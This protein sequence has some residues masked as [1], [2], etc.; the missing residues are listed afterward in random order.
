MFSQ[1]IAD[2]LG[3]QILSNRNKLASF[4]LDTLVLPESRLSSTVDHNCA[5]SLLLICTVAIFFV[6]TLCQ[7]YIHLIHAV[8]HRLHRWWSM[9]ADGASAICPRF[10][11]NF[12]VKLLFVLLDLW[13]LLLLVKIITNLKSNPVSESLVVNQNLILDAWEFL[14]DWNEISTLQL[15]WIVHLHDIIKLWVGNVSISILVNFFNCGHNWVNLIVSG[16]NLDQLLLTYGCLW[17]L[18]PIEFSDSIVAIDILGLVSALN[19]LDVYFLIEFLKKQVIFVIVN[20]C[21]VYVWLILIIISFVS[22][23]GIQDLIL[24]DFR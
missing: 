4:L 3:V 21:N 9:L 8:K 19:V 15:I 2:L 5:R 14:N 18:L 17:N 23:E 13:L 10:C 1:G 22:W 7:I 12:S 6:N 16:Y 11:L 20:P 24:F